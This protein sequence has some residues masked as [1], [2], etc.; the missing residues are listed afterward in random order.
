M[1]DL[2]KRFGLALAVLMLF[3]LVPL[4]AAQNSATVQVAENAT[5]GKI[6]TD[7]QGMTLYLFTKDAENVSNCYDQCAV[8]WPPLLAEAGAEPSAGEG[9]PGQLGVIERTDGDRQVTYN[10]M[11]LYYFVN[12]SQPGDTN[13]QYVG[14]VWFVVHPDISSM[15]VN[16]PQVQTSEDPS[17]GTILTSQGMTLYRFAQDEAD[18]SNCY[19]QCAANWPPLLASSG[20][21]TAG[22]GLTGQLGVIERTDGGR[23]V[24]YNGQ[25]LYFFIQDSKFGDTTGQGVGG[26]WFV[27]NPADT[28][29]AAPAAPAAATPA[30]PAAATPPATM[31][32]TGGAPTLSLWASLLLLAAGGLVLGGGLALA[33]ARRKH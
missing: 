11:P 6:L 22:E 14:G 28:A 19:D 7:S 21:P 29:M 26:V 33:H 9:V 32:E 15:T 13:G 4:A 5:Q 25:P 8:A 20:E 18:V 10:G 17:L 1:F 23:Q 3:G 24:T 12:D 2:R 31:P 30:A 27:V 16:S